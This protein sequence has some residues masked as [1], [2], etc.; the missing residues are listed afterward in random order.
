MRL[1][2][3]QQ[4]DGEFPTVEITADGL[5]FLKERRAVTLT[6][7]PAKLARP[8]KG[9][10]PTSSKSRPYRAGEI[11][12]DEALFEK[13]RQLRRE[14]ADGLHVP[15]YIVFGDV[16]LRAMARDY[17]STEREFAGITGVGLKKLQEFGAPFIEAIA[18]HLRENPRQAF[19][20]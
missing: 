16:S 20:D 9:E 4:N 15:A 14:L 13:L 18:Q 19:L 3:L 1:G 17:P 7:P 2:F 12:C 11:V 5:Q 6:R 10:A 8:S